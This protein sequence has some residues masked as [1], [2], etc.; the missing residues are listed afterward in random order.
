MNASYRY[1]AYP[2]LIAL[3]CYVVSAESNAA[4]YSSTKVEFLYGYGYKRGPN[5]SETNE[6]MLTIANATGFTWG[7][8]YFFLDTSNVDDTDETGGTHIEI[9][10]R[11][12]FWKAEKGAT[13]KSFYGIV[14]ADI[15]SNRFT[16]KIT[17]MA[18]A[19]LDWAIPGVKFLKTHLQYRDDP[20]LDGSSVQFTLVWNSAFTLGDENFSFEGFADWTSSEGTSSANLL[21]QPQLLWH[22]SKHI[23][24]GVEYQYWKNRLGIEGLDEKTPQIMLRWTF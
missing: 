9:G 6:A 15:D 13:I 14:Q 7:D 3:P 1:I 5:F 20:T 23:A 16:Q 11:Y 21:T 10:P 18:G 19:S 12:R 24:V 8:S 22:G 2:F 17:P 4:T